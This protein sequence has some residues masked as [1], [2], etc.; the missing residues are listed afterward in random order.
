MASNPMFLTMLCE[1]ARD[2]DLS[3]LPG[4]SY[5]VFDLY[6]EKRLTRDFDR[7]KNSF[8][9]TSA[10]LRLA[11][12][13]LAYSMTAEAESRSRSDEATTTSRYCQAKCEP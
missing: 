1:Y 13:R 7:I 6:I 3:T 2:H 8:G 11:T 5:V 4:N 12:E 10:D 9:I